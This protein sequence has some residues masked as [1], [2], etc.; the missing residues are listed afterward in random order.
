MEII[1]DNLSNALGS[2][3]AAVLWA[4]QVWK[5]NG[6][7]YIR[8]MD[9]KFPKIVGGFYADRVVT[10]TLHHR[11]APLTQVRLCISRARGVLTFQWSIFPII[12]VITGYIHDSFA[13]LFQRSATPSTNSFVYSLHMFSASSK[14]LEHGNSPREKSQRQQ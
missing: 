8:T 4:F 5:A 14:N 2:K 10:A 7:K 1:R 3:P 12:I 9:H 13:C 11:V 6:A